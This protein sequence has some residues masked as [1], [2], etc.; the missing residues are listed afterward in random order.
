VP[1]GKRESTYKNKNYLKVASAFA[2]PTVK[3]IRGAR[4]N[5]PGVQPR[6]APGIQFVDIP[7]FPALGTQ[8]SQ[9]VSSAIAG[10]MS[11]SEALRRGQALADDVAETYRTREEK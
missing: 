7:E 11:V 3:A 4:P 10:Q 5:D 8:V 9:Y 2:N 1:A 6:P